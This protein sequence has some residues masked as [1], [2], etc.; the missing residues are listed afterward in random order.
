MLLADALGYAVRKLRPDLLVDVATLTGAMKISLGLRTAGF[1]A[2][3]EELADRITAAGDSVGERWWRMPLLDAHAEDVA[4]EMGDVR[5]G[6][7]GPG[8]VMAALFLR[9]FTAGLPWAHMDI[10]GPARS[11][12]TYAEVTPGGTGFAARTLIALAESLADSARG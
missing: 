1:F 7:P 11:D 8:G 2:T 5:Q 12:K 4:G 9:E 6:P 10:A 3:D